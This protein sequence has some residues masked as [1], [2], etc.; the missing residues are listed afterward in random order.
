MIAT[1]AYWFLTRGTGAVSLLLLTGV[2]VLGIT[3]SVGWASSRWPRFITQ[4]LHRNL[5]LMAVAFLGVH[6]ATAVFDSYAPIRWADALLP[7]TSA[8]RPVWLGLG[9]VG[10]DLLVALVITSLVRVRLGYR[11][12]KAIHWLAY[13]C[14][15]VALLHG[16]GTGSDTSA[17]WMLLLD[18]GCLASV[19]GAVWWRAYSVQPPQALPRLAAFGATA[20]GTFGVAVWLLAG[21]LAPGWANAAGTPA[22]TPPAARVQSA[23]TSLPTNSAFTAQASQRANADGSVELDIVGTLDTSEMPIEILLGGTATPDGLSVRRGQVSLGVAPTKYVGAIESL[24]GGRI[25]ARL[26]DAAGTTVDV[27]LTMQIVDQA[28]TTHGTMHL[29]PAGSSI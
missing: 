12:W 26:T 7:F 27:D 8:Y 2:V 19:V 14:W 13:A 21:P 18:A 16:L 4:G 17:A 29:T 11:S 28:G 9:A 3:G 24:Q 22:H 6:V 10:F 23:S 5:S 25:V 15:P 1:Q 20:T